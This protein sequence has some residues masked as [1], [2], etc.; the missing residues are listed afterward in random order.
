MQFH[1][2]VRKTLKNGKVNEF[3]VPKNDD[4]ILCP[5]RAYQSYVEGS[6]SMGIDLSKGYVFRTLD[7]SR[8]MV[9]EDPV[10][11]STMFMRL[12]Y[13]L[14]L[15]NIDEGETPHG[16][17]GACAISLALS[18]A[19]TEDIMSHVGWSSDFTYKRYSRVGEMLG[20]R[21]VSSKMAGYAKN[22]YSEKDFH[23]LGGGV[24]N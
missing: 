13:Y 19:A 1:H 5:L 11:F 21:S 4:S 18:G 3:V 23:N 14:G 10:S 22:D 6:R 9:T 15:L 20:S 7:D 12:K 2:T 16:I 17:R 24:Y 8:S